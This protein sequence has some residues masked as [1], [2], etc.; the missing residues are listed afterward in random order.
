MH[1]TRAQRSRQARRRPRP[2]GAPRTV[3]PSLF[4]NA[5]FATCQTI[6]LFFAGT[7]RNWKNLKF[8]VE[9]LLVFEGVSDCIKQE[10]SAARAAEDRKA[11]AKLILTIDP[12][13]YVHNKE[14]TSPNDLWQKLKT[15]F[16]DH[17]LY[18]DPVNVR[19]A[20]KTPDRYKWIAAMKDELQ[21]SDENDARIPVEELF[22]SKTLV[23]WSAMSWE[24]KKQRTVALS[25]MKT[26]Y[27]S[28]AEPSKEAI[29][30]K[31]LLY[32]LPGSNNSPRRLYAPATFSLQIKGLAILK[33]P[34]WRNASRGDDDY[35]DRRLNVLSQLRSALIR[36][37]SKRVQSRY[38]PPRP[39]EGRPTIRGRA[40][41]ELPSSSLSNG[42]ILIPAFGIQTLGRRGPASRCTTSATRRRMKLSECFAKQP[43]N[44]PRFDGK[45]GTFGRPE[46]GHGVVIENR[47]GRTCRRAQTRSRRVFVCICLVNN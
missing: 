27:M 24:S 1:E 26:E 38:L 18:S 29:Y 47:R 22:S 12:P 14:A 33:F 2:S 9:N 41:L 30:L 25:N 37:K 11:I 28:I 13:L 3:R 39:S 44:R 35:R 31:S 17:E 20:I 34:R 43:N 46:R 45:R 19:E 15:M 36:F 16:D 6:C 4:K 40:A 42:E 8:I 23:Q 5:M 32:E 21:A 10:S 7:Y